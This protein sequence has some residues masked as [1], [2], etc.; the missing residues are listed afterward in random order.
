MGMN[1]FTICA[2][3]HKVLTP[4]IPKPAD[5]KISHGICQACADKMK[6]EFKKGK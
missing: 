1:I 6:E 3:C 2:W 5:N 4:D